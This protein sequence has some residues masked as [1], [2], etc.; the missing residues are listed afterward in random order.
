MARQS[1]TT[2]SPF[3]SEWQNGARARAIAAAVLNQFDPGRSYASH[4][5]D[6]LIEQ[7]S[8]KQRATDLVFGTIRNR[9]AIDTVIEVVGGCPI[10]RISFKPLNIVRIGTYELIYSPTSPPYSIVNEAVENAKAMAGKKQAGFVNAVLRE[11]T[12]HI[13]NRQALLPEAD[14]RRTLPATFLIGCEFDICLLPEPKR[15]RGAYLSRAFSLPEWLVAEWL[16]EFGADKTRRICFASNRKPSIYIRPNILRTTAQQ[17]AERFES[18]DSEVETEILA[19]E[20]MLRTRSPRAVAKLPGFAE[21]LFTVQD[22]TASQAVKAL[23]PRGDWTILDLCAAP[24]AKTT[25]L[26]ELTGDKA[27]IIA[28]DIDED[29]LQ[30]VTENIARLGINSVRVV[31]YKNLQKVSPETGPFDAVIVDAPCSNSGVL[32]KRVEARYRINPKLIASLTK[33]QAQLLAAAAKMTK[34]GGKIC[35]STCSIQKVENSQL[36][37]QFLLQD[38]DYELESELL[39][40]PSAGEIDCDGGY[41]AILGRKT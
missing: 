7:T 22:I 12:R 2:G 39:L 37:R 20:P 10:E 32:A 30:R 25:Q 29:R 26:A 15:S 14:A 13:H 1:Q 36:V 9:V 40:L 28:T 35:Y 18:A 11:I 17:L 27:R 6:R 38:R 33:T 3:S 16:K 21:G 24:G 34:S 8:E 23:K 4:I 41:V 5:L 31:A 19:D